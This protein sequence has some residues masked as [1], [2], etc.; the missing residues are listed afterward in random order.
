MSRGVVAF[1]SF[2]SELF[3]SLSNDLFLDFISF[4]KKEVSQEVSWVIRN[5]LAKVDES[6]GQV[7]HDL[8]HQVLTDGLRSL[9]Q[10]VSLVIAD[11][12]KLGSF[13][14]LSLTAILSSIFV[15]KF[16]LSCFMFSSSCFDFLPLN[17]GFNFVDV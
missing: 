13:A 8:I 3:I 16:F 11:L 5:V 7:R 4:L 6:L 2:F 15:K 1:S 14:F 9:V 10:K 17:K 12:L